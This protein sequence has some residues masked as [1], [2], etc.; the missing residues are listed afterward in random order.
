LMYLIDFLAYIFW[1]QKREFHQFSN[2]I[3]VIST[4]S[5]DTGATQ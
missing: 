5:S 4:Y 1:L 2:N 3:E